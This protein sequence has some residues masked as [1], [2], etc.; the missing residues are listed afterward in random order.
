[1]SDRAPT[2]YIRLRKRVKRSRSEPILL[3]HVAQ[4]IVDP[5][6]EEKLRNLELAR[7]QKKDGNYVLI[8]MM[9][10]V[11]KLK[12]I[13]PHATIEH[14]GEPH[15]IVELQTQ[16]RPANVMLLVLVWILLFVGSGMAIMNFHTDVSMPLVHQKL[17]RMITGIRDEHP[18]VLQIPYSL[19]I[20]AGMILFFN[21]LF[22]KKFNEEPN[23]L[24]VEMFMYEE[25]VH[26]YVVTDEYEKMQKQD[27]QRLDESRR[28]RP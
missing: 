9:Q 27:G 12:Q 21:R 24:E 26:Q 25:S 23:P 14:F 16:A 18:L 1:M 6:W 11:G 13:M 17:Y 4:I 20:G 7:P 2:V 22:R 8:D 19:G 15:T 10:I 28:D 3:K 5:P